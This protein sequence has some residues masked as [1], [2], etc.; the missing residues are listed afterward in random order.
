MNERE[1]LDINAGREYFLGV[2][3]TYWKKRKFSMEMKIG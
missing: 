2:Q 3:R 1:E